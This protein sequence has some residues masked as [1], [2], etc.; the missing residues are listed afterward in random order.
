M[1]KVIKYFEDL[2]DSR[3][4]YH[5]GDTFPHDGREVSEERLAELS[6]DTNKRHTPLIEKV[7]EEI[8]EEV[9]E[10]EPE[11]K[12]KETEAKKPRK[13]AKKG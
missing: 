10:A 4:A 2:E 7:V 9:P 11:E 1:Y 8:R 13:R 12:P 3:Y 5:V 6:S